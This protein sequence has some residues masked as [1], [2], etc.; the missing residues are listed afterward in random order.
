MFFLYFYFPA[1]IPASIGPCWN[2]ECRVPTCNDQTGVLGGCELRIRPTNGSDSGVH[3]WC[4]PIA[5][6]VHVH[7]P[8]PNHWTIHVRS[9]LI[10]QRQ[11][12]GSVW[13]DWGESVVDKSFE[14]SVLAS[15]FLYCFVF[16]ELYLRWRSFH[17]FLWICVFG[18][19]ADFL[20]PLFRWIF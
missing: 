10:P 2:S 9:A 1:Q 14:I 20:S 11:T 8:C 12:F 7:S 17:R 16:A 19:V 15:A 3:C 4:A 13:P 6:L 5:C 18:I